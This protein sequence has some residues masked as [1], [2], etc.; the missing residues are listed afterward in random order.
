ML[1]TAG[2]AS[3][4]AQERD[5]IS[6]QISASLVRCPAVKRREVRA[7]HTYTQQTQLQPAGYA[8]ASQL[9]SALDERYELWLFGSLLSVVAHD[10]QLSNPGVS[11]TSHSQTAS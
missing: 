9:C 7:R 10:S 1:S 6:Q 11:F 2:V 4:H 8:C 5:R 3:V